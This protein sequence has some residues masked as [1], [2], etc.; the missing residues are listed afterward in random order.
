MPWHT[1]RED[2]GLTVARRMPPRFDVA[3]SAAFP[4]ARKGRL[5]HQIRQDLWRMLRHLP[6]FSP[7]VRVME[8]GPYLTVTAGGRIDGRGFPKAETEARIAALLV[9]PAHRTRWMRH[10]RPTDGAGA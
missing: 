1:L 7:V 2:T 3:A 10:A 6:G 9:S 4:P 5:A 8:D